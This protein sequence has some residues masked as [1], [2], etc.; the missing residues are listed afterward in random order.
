MNMRI[1]IAKEMR[2]G[3][4][5]S[6][7]LILAAGFFFF[8]LLDPVM[9]KIILPLIIKS[10]FPDMSGDALSGMF[11]ISQTAAVQNYMNDIF[12]MGT[13][14]V[15]FTLCGVI[16]QEI[17]EKTLI[18]P[19]CSGHS[20]GGIIAGKFIV[21]GAAL[22]LLTTAA[23]ATD[24]VYAGMLMGFDSISWITIFRG[25]L[26]QGLYMVFVL[27]CLMAFGA[28]LGRPIA[29]GIL[30]LIVA[31]GSFALGD[32]LNISRYM[33]GGLIKEAALLS[34]LPSPTLPVTVLIT[35]VVIAAL[36]G[37]TLVR[38]RNMELNG[39]SRA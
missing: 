27:S 7:F 14:I 35:A 20:F 38:L 24:Y 10:Q 18:F 16:A 36:Y 11:K 8:A 1:N 21:F 5:N 39:G 32:L 12:E 2:F 15:A 37:L 6:K 26:L 29:T 9:I 4:R 25:G 13:L 3:A 34:N 33:P 23:L 22:I 19:V 31:Y 30:T 17:R 28:L